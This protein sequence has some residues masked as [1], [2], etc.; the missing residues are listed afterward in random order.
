VENRREE[1]RKTMQGGD[2]WREAAAFL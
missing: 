2:T 1:D